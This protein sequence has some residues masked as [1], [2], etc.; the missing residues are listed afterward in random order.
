MNSNLS[1][2]KRQVTKLPQTTRSFLLDNGPDWHKHQYQ[3]I[4]S[5]LPLHYL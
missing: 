3:S 2:R 1:K 4:E 5:I